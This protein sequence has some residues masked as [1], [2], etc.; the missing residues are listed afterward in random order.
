MLVIEKELGRKRIQPRVE[1]L[2]G[3]RDVDLPVLHAKVVSVNRQRGKRDGA[4][5]QKG[6]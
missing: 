6:K 4:Q 1:Q 5:A 2:L 3:R